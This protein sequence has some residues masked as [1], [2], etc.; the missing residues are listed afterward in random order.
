MG[1][2]PAPTDAPRAPLTRERIVALA[3]A[4][5]DREGL[6]ALNMRRLADEA[7][8]KP[9][10]LYHHFPNKRAILDGVAESIA[11]AA[12]AGRRPAG[13]WQG[14]VRTLFSQLH[15]LVRAHPR[16]LPLISTAV[17]GTPSG[18][19]WMEELLRV[20]LEAGF[21][22]DRAAATYHTLG[23]YT[24]GLGYADLL[25]LEVSP[26]SVVRRLAGHWADYPNMLRVGMRLLAWDAPG[27][28]ETGF[29]ALLAPFASQAS[30]GAAPEEGGRS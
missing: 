21:S 17:I 3:L 10:S 22:P 24:L 13:D 29:D 27:E 26:E 23:A 15:R 1:T 9:M 14:Q 5:V 16:A 11:A 30:D 20:L 12:L 2:G 8:V 25:G 18:R 19:R 6:P 4:I 28:F 7:G